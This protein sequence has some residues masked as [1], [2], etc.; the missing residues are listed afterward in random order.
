M[1]SDDLTLEVLKQIRDGLGGM[2]DDFNARFQ[3]LEGEVRGMGQRLERVEAGLND[4]GQFMRQIALDQTKYERF[5]AHHVEVLEK[6]LED[7]R[8][9]VRRL[10]ERSG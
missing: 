10:E 2:R 1:S 3:S 9:R 8:A 4:L 6:D 7:V 5:H